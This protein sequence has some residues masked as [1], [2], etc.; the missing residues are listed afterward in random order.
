MYEDFYGLNEAPFSILPDPAFLY[1]GKRHSLAYATLEYGLEHRAGFTVVTGEVGVGKTTLIRH[2]LN[3]LE[4]A[5]TVGLMSNTQIEPEELFGWILMSFGQPYDARRKVALFD[6]FQQFVI[7]EYRAGRRVVLIID[8]AQ[9]LPASVLEELRMLSNINVDKDQLL[10]LVLVG[11]PY[12]RELLCRPDLA[13]LVQRVT[14]DFQLPP[15]DRDEVPRYIGH[16]LSVAGRTDPLFKVDA[17]ERIA[18]RAHGIPRTLNVLCDTALV[19]GYSA[20]VQRIGAEIIDELIADKEKFGVLP[21]TSGSSRFPSKADL[22]SLPD[23]FR[24]VGSSIHPKAGNE[25]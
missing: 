24:P 10:Q 7:D 25:V 8:E 9:N 15:L 20:R 3:H 12:F 19:Y 18:D 13:Q 17:I 6:R 22:R 5:V 16:R 11:Q 4:G 1:L 21:L 14:A 2:L 23:Y